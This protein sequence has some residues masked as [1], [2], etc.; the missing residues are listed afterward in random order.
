MNGYVRFR[1]AA[2]EDAPT[3]KPYQEA[4]WAELD[5]AKTAPI[6]VSLTLL[7]ALHERWIRLLRGYQAAD[8]ARRLNHPEIGELALSAY[9]S[10][11][12]WHGRHHVAH[13]TGLRARMGG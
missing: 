11:Y 10:S 4:K 7:E 6:E 9:L 13:I 8:F 2:T 1:L 12:A 3:I 5:D